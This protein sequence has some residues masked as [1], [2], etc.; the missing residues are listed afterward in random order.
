MDKHRWA[1]ILSD[2]QYNTLYRI[3][4]KINGLASYIEDNKEMDFISII[5]SYKHILIEMNTLT[6]G[7]KIN[8]ELLS[9]LY[10]LWEKEYNKKYNTAK[11]FNITNINEWEEKPKWADEMSVTEITYL[12]QFICQVPGMLTYIYKFKENG[13]LYD[14]ASDYQ[15]LLWNKGIKNN[16]IDF[17]INTIKERFYRIKGEH[18]NAIHYVNHSLRIDDED[19][20]SRFNKELEVLQENNSSESDREIFYKKYSNCNNPYISCNIFITQLRENKISIALDSIRNAL[21]Y[22]FASPNIY[23]H[24]KEAIYGATTMLC[25]IVEGLDTKGLYDINYTHPLYVN[26]ILK[27]LF[28]LLS[29]TIYWYDMETYKNETYDDVKLPINTQHKI[30][31]YRYRAK[32]TERY[33]DFFINE[34]CRKEHMFMAYSD[35]INAHN[36]AFS[37]NIVSTDS[38][39]KKDSV[40][41]FHEKD[42]YND[43][44]PEQAYERGKANNDGI[45][46]NLHK[47]YQAGKLILSKVQIN[48]LLN[49]L[50]DY[51]NKEL[52]YAKE[53]NRPISYLTRDNF[54]AAKKIDSDIIRNYLEANGIDFFYHFTE[55]QRIQSIKKYGGLFSYKRCLDEGIVIPVQENMALSRDIDAKLG[56]EDYARLSFS[57]SLPKI[58]ERQKEGADLVMLKISTEVALFEE[59]MF[60]DIEATHSSLKYGKNFED[61]KRVNLKATSRK[62]TDTQDPEYL[63]SQA[64]IL[65]KGFIPSKYILNLDNPETIL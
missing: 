56:L 21:Y 47:Q 11:I 45:A 6:T 53:S 17:L 42:L 48:E 57:K 30:R 52:S 10:D 32:I 25:D 49:I 39:Y 9:R 41:L 61:L 63:Q 13:N 54:S 23:W 1:N 58:V 51:L 31:A 37:N 3:I 5:K 55:R 34:F 2:S 43:V 28:L 26:N 35:L 64:E 59:T 46:M 62:I 19:I 12:N 38:C 15:I 7:R 40:R 8:I 24:N 14:I 60:T 36:V 20:I 29:R 18:K 27:V 33:G 22:I 4:D 50:N 16:Q 65:V 44:S